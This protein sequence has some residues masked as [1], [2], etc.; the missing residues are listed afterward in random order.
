MRH[1]LQPRVLN[2]AVLAAL[3]SA[4]ACY[5]RFSLWSAQ[6]VPIRYLEAAVF[7]CGI[8]L[9]SFVLAWHK[10]YTNRPVFFVKWDGKIFFVA[11]VGGI[12]LAAVCRFGLD[13]VLRQQLPE[14]YPADLAHWLA[15]VPFML[16]FGQLFLTFAPFDWLMRLCRNR[17]IAACLTALFGVGV[18]AL[19]LHPHA[20][21]IPPLMFTGLLAA[22]FVGGLLAAALYLHGGMVLALWWTLLLQ[23]RLL[24]EPI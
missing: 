21:S 1:L 5:P 2:Q 24:P 15:T 11:T 19:K 12:I 6:P 22:R 14:D 10:P 3:V 23:L 7:I 8:T 17:L 9:W 4:L 20:T 18:T 16:G 13:P